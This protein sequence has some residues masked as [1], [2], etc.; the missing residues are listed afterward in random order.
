MYK[1]LIWLMCPDGGVTER[2][3]HGHIIGAVVS[4]G[5][6]M[7]FAFAISMVHAGFSNYLDLIRTG[8][9]PVVEGEHIVILGYTDE[10][11]VLVE[12]LCAGFCDKG[13]TKIAILAEG[14]KSSVEANIRARM[15]R[16]TYQ[17]NNIVVRSGCSVDANA[18]QHVSVATAAVV[19]VMPNYNVEKEQRDALTL[20]TLFLLRRKG[21]P[22]QGKVLAACSIARNAQ[23]LERAGGSHTHLVMLN[24][25][26]AKLMSHC[27]LDHGLGMAINELVGFDGNAFFTEV[28]PEH[29]V[30][31]PFSEAVAYYS[32]AVVVGMISPST[33]PEAPPSQRR[34]SWASSLDNG[35]VLG[36]HATCDDSSDVCL[37]PVDCQL[38]VGAELLLVARKRLSAHASPAPAPSA[39]SRQTATVTALC[40][41]DE[42]GPMADDVGSLP[43]TDDQVCQI[44]EHGHTIIILGWNEWTAT[45]LIELDRILPPCSQAIVFDRKEVGSR[46]ETM[47]TAQ[48][49]WKRSLQ[50]IEVKNVEGQ[51]GSY[52][53]LEEKLTAPLE[54]GRRPPL[55]EAKTVF[56]L[57]RQD[58]T[59]EKADAYAVTTIL[60]I[61][62]IMRKHGLHNPDVSFVP[63]ISGS[64]THPVCKGAGISD[65]VSTSDLMAKV[66]AVHA[67]DT[68]IGSLLDILV[69]GTQ[70]EIGIRKL[71]DYLGAQAVPESVSFFDAARLTGLRGDVLLGWTE[72][73]P[74]SSCGGRFVLNPLDKGSPRPWTRGGE[75]LMVLHRRQRPAQAGPQIAEDHG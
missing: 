21:W 31:L 8:Y 52:W 13:A 33:C 65:Y 68:R 12:E 28:V 20:Q 69:S 62:D 73:H 45:V 72:E 3:T 43:Q 70:A 27:G 51:L 34:T 42:V 47:R 24:S 10:T 57:A 35:D 67:V 11:I 54:A 75:R 6:L 49:N 1:V 46:N 48:R 16:R 2:S 5:G 40:G 32:D 55:E 38:Q 39:R 15:H 36:A 22:L 14:E 53:Q 41:Y 7:I 26:V 25:F 19:I 23:L 44:T 60:H 17:S 71:E 61:R 4:L 66:L 59:P 63:Q 64:R 29:L 9:A 50:N 37:C 58:T 74:G 30:G 18:L 56:V